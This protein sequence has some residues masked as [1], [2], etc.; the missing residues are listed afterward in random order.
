MLFYVLFVC[1][2]VLY[3]CHR[4]T[5]QL[6]LTNISYQCRDCRIWSHSTTHTHSVGL[7]WTRDLP[8]V[9]TSTWQYT[10]LATDRHPYPPVG[11]KPAIPENGGPQTH[12]LNHRDRPGIKLSQDKIYQNEILLIMFNSS[13]R[14]VRRRIVPSSSQLLAYEYKVLGTVVSWTSCQYSPKTT[15]IIRIWTKASGY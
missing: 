9:E 3:Y 2:C 10:T 15:N 14:N 7:L 12:A 4:V 6:Q 11:L 5:T 8:V 13:V 1:K